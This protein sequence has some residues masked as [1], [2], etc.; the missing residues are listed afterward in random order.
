MMALQMA[1]E[2]HPVIPAGAPTGYRINT[3]KQAPSLVLRAE[4]DEV[5]LEYY[6]T[7]IQK[8]G[9]A[10]CPPLYTPQELKASFWPN[11]H[12][13][14]SPTGRLFLVQDADGRLVGCGTLHQVRPDACEVKRLYIRPEAE[15]H[16]LG[17]AVIRAWIAAAH[18]IGVSRILLNVIKSNLTPIRIYESL[19]FKRIVRYPECAD[20]I[21][22][23]PYFVYLEYEVT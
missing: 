8:L 4:L 16:G 1:N 3:L 2:P 11:L 22:V 12:S 7:I 6:S 15:G 9:E 19:G 23:D 13:Y 21:E 14:L 18:E 5:L 10:G 17:R 20:P